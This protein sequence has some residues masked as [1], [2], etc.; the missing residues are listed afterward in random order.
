MKKLFFILL[1]VPIISCSSSKDY[2]IVVNFS[3]QLQANLYDSNPSSTP[4][5][6]NQK[7][8]VSKNTNN[9]KKTTVETNNYSDS[10]FK[11]LNLKSKIYFAFDSYQLEDD[12]VKAI[13]EVYSYLMKN[14]TDIIVVEGHSDTSG[15]YYYNIY[16]SE[17]RAR[18]IVDA[19]ISKGVDRKRLGYI[20]FGPTKSMSK[21]NKTERY[22]DFI[23]IKN[24]NELAYY[25]KRNEQEYIV[26]NRP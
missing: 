17:M 16:L 22:S 5:Y 14:P 24:N 10:T 11:S 2:I 8:T 13:D 7:S 21:Y 25:K 18:S 15:D 6:N 4:P 23:I 19:L 12:S 1:T 3:R 20:G 9:T 26:L